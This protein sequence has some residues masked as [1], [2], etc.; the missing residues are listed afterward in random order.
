MTMA[1]SKA[2]FMGMSAAELLRWCADGLGPDD[3]HRCCE[4]LRVALDAD[5]DV[6][7]F[8]QLADRIDAEMVE[9]PRDKDGV[10]IHVGSTVYLKDGH[11]TVVHSIDL[12][13]DSARIIC[14]ENGSGYLPFNQSDLSNKPADSLERIA[15]DIERAE[16]WCDQ[17][18][19]Y[20]T[21]VTSVEERTLRDW[22]ERIRKLAE[23]ED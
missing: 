3:I 20:G 13:A 21:G 11:R 8:N 16:K 10:P 14:W 2:D 18:G 9:L 6:C 22:A 7:A 19:H 23:N 15:D 4:N 1:M 5:T 12:M 17:N